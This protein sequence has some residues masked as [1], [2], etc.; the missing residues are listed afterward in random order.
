MPESEIFHSAPNLSEGRSPALISD[1]QLRLSPIQGLELADVSSDHDHHRTVVSL[2]GPAPVLQQAILALFEIASTHIDMS[3]HRGEHPRVGAVDVVPF[4]PLWSTPMDSAIKAAQ[5][6][7]AMVAE[8]FNLP[9]Y[10]YEYAAKQE[11]RRTLPQVRKGQMEGLAQQLT[12]GENLPD[13]GP[14]AIHPKLGACIVGARRPLAAYNVVLKSN[15]LD[16]AKQIAKSIRTLKTKPVGAEQVSAKDLATSGTYPAVSGAVSGGQQIRALAIRLDSRE[17]VQISMNLINPAQTGILDAYLA[18]AAAAAKFGIEIE[19]SEL[20]GL[21][22]QSLLLD[23]AAHFLK[24]EQGS[25]PLQQQ[26]LEQHFL[27]EQLCSQNKNA[28]HNIWQIT[29]QT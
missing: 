21:T 24:L 14:A 15:D 2:I 8:R 1:I 25:Q 12:R 3:Q 20:I 4:I 9:V 22:S 29:A 11:S 7:A 13:F 28:R 19:S 10:L 5:E 6:T 16:I 27:G 23:V 26:T 17:R 18:V